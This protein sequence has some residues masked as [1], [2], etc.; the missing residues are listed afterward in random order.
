MKKGINYVPL[1]VLIIGVMVGSGF[2]G[3]WLSFTGWTMSF[4]LL[5][6]VYYLRFIK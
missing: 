5:C 4:L 3:N 6:E 1:L 2:L